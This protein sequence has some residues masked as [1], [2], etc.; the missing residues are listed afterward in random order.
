MFGTDIEEKEEE[1]EK[2]NHPHSSLLLLLGCAVI[3]AFIGSL[4]L[5]SALTP[6]SQTCNEQNSPIT[7]TVSYKN[8]SSTFDTYS[9]HCLLNTVKVPTGSP[10]QFSIHSP[11][12]PVLRCLPYGDEPCPKFTL[13]KVDEGW[14]TTMTFPRIGA[15]IFTVESQSSAIHIIDCSGMERCPPI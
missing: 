5:V 6:E 2:N 7:L 8:E 12:P 13:V 10:V 1:K 14:S 9:N 3:L 11:Q 15:F 4:I